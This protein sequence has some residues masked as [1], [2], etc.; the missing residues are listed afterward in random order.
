[1]FVFR[2]CFVDALHTLNDHIITAGNFVN[3]GSLLGALIKEIA[4][5]SFATIPID[6]QSSFLAPFDTGNT[7]VDVQK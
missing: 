4:D 2:I 1:M 7:W 6:I 3:D 5:S